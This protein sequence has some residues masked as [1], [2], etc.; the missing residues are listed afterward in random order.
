[1]KTTTIEVTHKRSVWSLWLYK[2]L[3]MASLAMAV[4]GILLPGLPATEFV[5]L[6][7][8]AA[9]KGSPTIHHWIM[10]VP[11]FRRMIDNWQNGRVISRRNKIHSALS[12]AGCLTVLVAMEVAGIWLLV[13]LGGMSIGAF[14]IWR[15]PES[16]PVER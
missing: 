8:W 16:R 14:F 11:Y 6:A 13:A 10:S 3:A 4:V 1:M 7:A 12:M 9:A 5:I 15:R 2:L